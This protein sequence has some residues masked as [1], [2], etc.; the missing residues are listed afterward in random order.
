FGVEE[1]TPPSSYRVQASEIAA[2]IPVPMFS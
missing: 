1:A 2:L